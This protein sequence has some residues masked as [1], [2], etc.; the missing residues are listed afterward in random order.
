[1]ASEQAGGR[2]VPRGTRTPVSSLR[3]GSGRPC[4]G[5]PCDPPAGAPLRCCDL[6]Y[7]P[8]HP[9]PLP[10][11]GPAALPALTRR[12]RLGLAGLLL[13]EAGHELR[14]VHVGDEDRSVD[15]QRGQAA[16]DA[17]QVVVR[18]R[19]PAVRGTGVVSHGHSEGLPGRGA[20]DEADRGE[21]IT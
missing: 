20:G 6:T 18:R 13:H 1:M 9:R 8:H 4:P 5:P 12:R 10:Q 7:F 14:G 11:P 17:G 16:G 21:G 15:V 2:P 3:P 19:L